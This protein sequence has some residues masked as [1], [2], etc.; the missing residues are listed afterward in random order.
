MYHKRQKELSFFVAVKHEQ[1]NL[2]LST[3]SFGYL[4]ADSLVSV[5]S[6]TSPIQ[7]AAARDRGWTSLGSPY[8]TTEL[9]TWHQNIGMIYSVTGNDQ[10]RRA[11]GNIIKYR[12]RS[13]TKTTQYIA[14]RAYVLRTFS[15]NSL[16]SN[17]CKMSSKPISCTSSLLSSSSEVIMRPSGQFPSRRAIKCRE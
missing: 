11:D 14:E 16:L 10:I 5:D 8:R 7:W 3:V 12:V 15:N 13:P 6:V 17:L 2:T 4:W 1:L 9:T